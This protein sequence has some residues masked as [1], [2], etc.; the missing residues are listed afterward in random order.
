MAAPLVLVTGAFGLLGGCLVKRLRIRGARIRLVG[1]MPPAD[2]RAVGRE[3]RQVDLR[4]TVA[5][6]A[7]RTIAAALLVL[8]TA[9]VTEARSART[10]CT[11]LFAIAPEDAALLGEGAPPV[12]G[13]EVAASGRVTLG[14]CGPTVTRLRA[15][16]RATI[17]KAVWRT[18]DGLGHV[19][20][21]ARIASPACDLF[22]GTVKR[23]RAAGIHFTATRIACGNA[24]VDASEACDAS[25]PAGDVA[26]PGA[27]SACKC[28]SPTSSTSTT[29]STTSTT[30]PD[31]PAITAP[32]GTWTWVPFPDTTCDEGSA[33]GLGVNLADSPNVAIILGAGGLCWDA[34]TCWV[35]NTAVHG[36]FGATELANALPFFAG[37]I[38]DR[39]LAG[40][41]FATWNLIVVPYCTGDLHAGDNVVVY[42][43]GDA[44]HVHHHAGYANLT[45]FLR[46][47]GPT[48]PSPG[49]VVLGGISAGGFGTLFDFP[50]VRARW[51]TAQT[52]VLDDSGPL[53]EAPP[54]PIGFT[55][56]LLNWRLDLVMDPTCGMPCRSDQSMMFPA[57]SALV[58]SARL[59]LV[60]SVQDAS[61]RALYGL[62][63]S[64]FEDA[65]TA[66]A[67]DR[68]DPTANV[69]YFFVAGDTH[70][71]LAAPA[72]VS[73]N[74]VAL[75]DW[76]DQLV[77]DD[78]GWTSVHP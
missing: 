5:V 46:R 23:P 54:P 15:N 68:I 13:L 39:S 78:P 75:L 29:I 26:C 27:C 37:S 10:P 58:P 36:P 9:L 61:V 20:L 19:R 57:L 33:T 60:S 32:D 1:I 53:L 2:D 24:R 31:G 43:T 64:G 25:A 63:S 44:T 65:L 21:R 40:N 11:G 28:V 50:T 47:L 51:P 70:A 66:L 48:F 71:Q 74:G 38:L 55:D 42:D 34:T 17:F 8:A 72:A 41:P 22:A 12:E 59:A 6:A 45:S 4:D 30:A 35:T 52:Y 62:T 67:T 56:W 7:M 73:Q 18:C 49:K 3:F 69:R 16:R 77:N 76:I 14:A